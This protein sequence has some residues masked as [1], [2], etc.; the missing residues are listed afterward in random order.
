[1]ASIRSKIFYYIIKGLK[2]KYRVGSVKE[3][4]RMLNRL[5]RFSVHPSRTIIAPDNI[6]NIPV[7]WITVGNNVD[8]KSVILYLHGG[9]YS[10][11]SL[12]T[13]QGIAAHISESSGVKTLLIDYRLAPEHPFPTGFNDAVASYLWLLSNG[14][15][16]DKII[17]CG[18]SAGGGL[19]MATL[20]SLRDKGILLPAAAVCISPWVDLTKTNKYESMNSVDDPVL[21]RERLQIMAE[22]Y[23]AK[24]DPRL[25]LISPVFADLTG[26][27]PLLIQVGT[28]EILQNDACRLKDRAVKDGVGVVLDVWDDMWHVWH[29]LT[30]YI[31][32]AK[33]AID[34]IGDFIRKHINSYQQ[35]K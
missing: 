21:D 2:R 11:G 16:S 18:D 3:L 8:D 32:E 1:M 31:P 9:S 22:Y 12:N 20:I 14:Y 33:Q 23:I 27:P 30:G 34:K 19:V 35:D 7:N 13:H 17:I 6:H 28:K 26:L 5:A 24:N 29:A 10:L 15:T 4:R 25:P